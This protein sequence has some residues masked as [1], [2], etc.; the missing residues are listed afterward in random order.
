MILL[1]VFS[2]AQAASHLL[3]L[4]KN[5]KPAVEKVGFSGN[6]EA[7]TCSVYSSQISQQTAIHGSSA[8]ITP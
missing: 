4:L 6:L 2:E 7:E 3:C 5:K 8:S 1:F